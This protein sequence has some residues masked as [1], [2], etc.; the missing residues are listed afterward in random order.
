[1]KFFGVGISDLA[2]KIIKYLRSPIAQS[3]A[4]FSEFL[5]P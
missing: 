3:L 4:Q 1:M 2:I 5:L